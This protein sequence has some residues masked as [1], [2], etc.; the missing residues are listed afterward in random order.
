[1]TAESWRNLLLETPAAIGEL[2]E[3]THRVAVLGIK[4]EHT[5]PPAYFVPRYA[6]R[7]GL[8]IIPVPVYFPEVTE[9]LG[10]PVYR[11]LIDIPMPIDMVNVFRRPK[12]IPMH[13]ADILA[14]R[15]RSVWFQSGISHDAV[16]EAFARAGIQVVQDKCLL[17]ELQRRGR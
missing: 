10:R 9:I 2:L 4:T 16:A 6:Q 17:V 13:V 5:N 7:A 1:M 14:T 15:P 3:Q 11:R 12:D 8:E